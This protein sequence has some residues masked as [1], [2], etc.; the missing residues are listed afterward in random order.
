MPYL[1][2]I[3]DDYPEENIGEYVRAKSPDA[4]LFRKG[5]A[6]SSDVGIPIVRFDS[7]L[8]V[9]AN[10]ACLPNSSTLPLV[11]EN[12]AIA[13]VNL[14]PNNIQL[15]Q[16]RIVASDGENDSFFTL[17]ITSKV[18]GIN[19]NRSQFI[20]ITGTDH[21][22]SFSELEYFDDCLG[23]NLIAREAD[24]LPHI[25][26]SAVLVE[27]LKELKVSTLGAAFLRSNEISW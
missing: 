5:T 15:I 2:R 7:P 14:A 27:T 22:R 4:A 21:I 18:S 10:Y 16:S 9:L 6:A 26:V 11:N 3:P 20:L 19:K 25:L 24:Y 13:L 17:N 8:A 12:L 1:W 23:H